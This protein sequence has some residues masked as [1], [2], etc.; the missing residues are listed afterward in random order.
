MDGTAPRPL[1]YD[2]TT[3]ALHWLTAL[4]V[5]IQWSIGQTI[6]DIPGRAAKQDYIGLHVTIGVLLACALLFRL[7]WRA[8]PGRRLP[9]ADRGVV[10]VVAKATH[11]G[12]YVLLAATAALGIAFA[13]SWGAP[14]YTIARIPAFA[15]GNRVLGK[16]LLGW[17]GTLADAVLILAGLHACAA[18]FHQYGL[19]D[20]LIRRMAP[21]RL[22]TP[23]R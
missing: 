13:L 10:H 15:P 14:F 4:L 7:A 11:W 19:R 8:G 12:L 18:L 21:A 5:A 23:D 16:A 3:I 22:T 9:A 17:H 20:R 6:D 1:R 2:S